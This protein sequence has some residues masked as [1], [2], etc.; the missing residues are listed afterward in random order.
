MP[1]EG[2]ASSPSGAAWAS[3]LTILGVTPNDRE[4]ARIHSVDG[5]HYEGGQSTRMADDPVAILRRLQAGYAISDATTA[6][7]ALPDVLNRVLAAVF[8][9]FHSAERAFILLV[10]PET[11]AVT[12]GASQR[13]ND[14]NDEDITISK[15]AL[16]DV[17]TNRKALLCRD[18]MQDDLLSEARSIT[19]EGIRSLMIAP[20]VF[21]QEVYGAMYADTRDADAAFS[22]ED[23]DLL[24]FAAAQVAGAVANAQLHGKVVESECL[25]AV[26]QTVAGLT[27]CI[28]NILQAVKG[29]TY[30]IDKGLA[31]EDLE[32]VAKG[33][34]ILKRQNRFM[35][36]LVWDLLNYSKPREPEYERV[37]LNSLCSDICAASSALTEA[38]DVVFHPGESLPRPEV[39]P[40]GVRRCLLNLVTNAIDACAQDGGRVTVTTRAAGGS[41]EVS[42]EDT[43][44]GMPKEVLDKLFKVFFT[45]KGSKGTGLGLPTTRKIVE[46]HGGRL[47]VRSEEG[48][49]TTFVV[50]LPVSCPGR[51]AP[52]ET[53]TS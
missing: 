23:L 40:K 52:Q 25:A 48:A 50:T 20:L 35:E 11:Q 13:R 45:T 26:G 7:L 5:T 27:H 16:H 31:A 53:M 21:R 42:V 28:K 32:R 37:D 49:G 46:E 9:I 30:I 12:T 29:G 14:E 6:T 4:P 44:T 41:V 10:D 34:E 38:V 24:S 18:A 17:L 19:E 43:G 36:Q 1:A 8:G 22:A 51:T 15:T 3:E 47:D 39:D 2:P 33:W